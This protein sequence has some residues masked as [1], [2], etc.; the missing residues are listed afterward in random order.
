MSN[1]EARTDTF[2]LSACAVISLQ[3]PLNSCER[4]TPELPLAPLREPLDIAFAILSMVGCSTIIT[5][6]TADIAVRVMLVPV[7]PS[8]TGNTFSSLILSF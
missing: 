2:T 5:A 4:I 3:K 1:A 7:S 6:F 8:G